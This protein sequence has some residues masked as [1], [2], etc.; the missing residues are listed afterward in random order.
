MVRVPL[1]VRE[2]FSGGTRNYIKFKNYLVFNS[3]AKKKNEQ[4]DGMLTINN[5]QKE[6]G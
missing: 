6:K 1:V 3:Y 4:K 2:T 5:L